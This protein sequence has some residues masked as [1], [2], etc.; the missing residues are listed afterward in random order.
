[1]QAIRSPRDP[2]LVLFAAAVEK[3]R[4]LYSEEAVKRATELVCRRFDIFLMRRHHEAHDPQRGLIVFAE[5][6]FHQRSRIWVRGFRE[7]G[8]EWGVLVNLS[9]IPYFASTRETRLLQ[10][11]DYVA[12]AAFLLYEKRNSE[13]IR[14]IIHRFDQKDGIIHGLVHEPRPAGCECPDCFSRRTPGSHGPWLAA[15]DTPPPN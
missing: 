4:Q 5:G 12:H 13:L 10:V 7:L 1:M 14:G 9:D 6:R 8:T 2:G 15:A 3:N 11:A